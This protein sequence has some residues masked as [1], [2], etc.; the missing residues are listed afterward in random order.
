VTGGPVTGRTES[1]DAMPKS[2]WRILL[3]LLAVVPA[4]A[5][6][7]GVPAPSA[8]A[9]PPSPV[10]HA[11][12]FYS[13]TCP[14]C[15][16]VMTV[17]LPPLVQRYGPRLQIA[18]VNVI[19][20]G[21]QALYQATIAHF[22][23][24][25]S[26]LGVPTLVVGTR[27]LVGSEEIPDELPGIVDRGLAAGGIAWPDVPEVRQALAQA[28]LAARREA[29]R[30]QIVAGSTARAAGD[31][32][33]RP[34]AAAAR[35]DTP[36]TV[37]APAAAAT[38]AD[39]AATGPR[40]TAAPRQ[41]ARQATDA[42]ARA[43]TAPPAPTSS[44]AIPPPRTQR[45]TP[46][47]G[48]SGRAIAAITSL[49]AEPAEGAVARLGARERFLLDPVGNSAAVAVLLLMVAALAVVALHIFGLR[50]PLPAARA[51]AVPV[52]CVAGLAVATYLAVVEVTGARA[53]CGPVGDCNTVQQSDYA[54]LFGVLPVG[55]LG[56]LGYVGMIGAWLLGVVGGEPAARAGRLGAWGLAL[57]ATVF[58][59]YLTF[60]EPFVIGATCAWCLSSAVI[61]TLLLLVLTPAARRDLA[62]LGFRGRAV[63]T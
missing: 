42:G 17:D 7:Q 25:D 44:A 51:W 10:V 13:P 55:V 34:A 18:T 28:E 9:T 27:V 32:A 54:R 23:L 57:V 20:T 5:F 39:T 30:Q 59:I 43:P 47:P 3:A 22:A 40:G 6:G 46:T 33:P 36:T 11:V 12:L 8:A 1:E 31:T 63:S 15:H 24:P 50:V 35:A 14:H 53:V 45:G 41:P 62:T 16:K 49:T 56:M 60:L 29:A 61:V 2:R 26:R 21:G 58:S 37:P 19:T 4:V 52:L 48:D 38:G